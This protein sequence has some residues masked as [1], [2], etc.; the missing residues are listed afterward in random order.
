MRN[1]EAPLIE[2]LARSG[3]AQ[4]LLARIGLDPAQFVLFLTLLR[5][6]GERQEF[7]GNLGINRLELGVIT[8]FYAV[9]VG[10]PVGLVVF[11]KLSAPLFLLCSLSVTL[12]LTLLIVVGEAANTLFNPTEAAVL[13]HRPVHSLTYA[14]AK[15]AHLL[16]VVLYLVPALTIPPAIFGLALLDARWFWPITHLAAGLLAGFFAAFLVCALYGWLYRFVPSRRL[17]SLS[18]WIQILPYA[19]MPALGGLVGGLIESLRG[20]NFD[21]SRWSW[22]PLVW[23][24]A[25]GLLGSRS[26]SEGV[27][28]E[29]LLALGFTSLAIWMGLRSFSGRYFSEV[30]GVTSGSGRASHSKSRMLLKAA[31]RRLTGAPAGLGAFSFTL[32]IMGRDWQF[33]RTALPVL[34]YFVVAL[35]PVFI[36]GKFPISPGTPHEFSPA[37][38][39]PH[40]L[41]LLLL[42]PCTMIAFSDQ[43]QGSSLFLNAPLTILRPFVRGIYLALWIPAVGITHIC[44]LPPLVFYWGWRDAVLF[45]GFSLVIV[46]GY[47]AVEMLLVAGI[48]FANP[49][50]AAKGAFSF[51]MLIVGGIGAAILGVL[52][53]LVFQIWWL[54]A[55]AGLALTVVVWFTAGATMSHAEEEIRRNLRALQ[56]GPTQMFKEIE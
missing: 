43:H 19:A 56:V 33:R 12:A 22:V 30:V 32:R 4:H 11:L 6:L 24:V 54:G 51:P 14:A 53:W 17:K 34:A 26:T 16:I 47:L 40:L 1:E 50:K 42:N 9:F 36:K 18:L 39:W 2:R 3:P 21:M 8:G 37:I 28:W 23:F 46:S 29:G 38:V 35:I 20:A 48:P 7:M 15:I 31:I 52:Q 44:I 13:A 27:G 55:I 45:T 49:Y 10:T 41:G 5:T 25:V